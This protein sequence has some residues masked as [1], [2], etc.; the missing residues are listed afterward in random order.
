MKPLPAISVTDRYRLKDLT[1]I[2]AGTVP[3]GRVMWCR[4]RKVLGYADVATLANVFAIP[5]SADTVCVSL[6]DHGD[7]VAWLG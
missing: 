7:I 4:G 2:P 1:L 3:A 5:K 6:A